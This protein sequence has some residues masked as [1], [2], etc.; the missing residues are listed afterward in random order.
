MEPG[1]VSQE[2]VH[3]EFGWHVIKVLD[4]RTAV[5]TFEE[6]EAERAT[7]P[8][9]RRSTSWSPRSTPAR[10]SSAST[11][12]ARR[13]PTRPRPAGERGRRRRGEE[14]PVSPLA[15]ERFPNPS[16][17]R[18]AV[19]LA[20]RGPALPGR[21]DVML[22]ELA[23]GSSVAGVLTRSTTAAPPGP[24][25]P[26]DPAARQGAGHHRQRR[27]RQRLHRQAGRQGGRGEAQAVG[28]GAGLPARGGVR[29]LDRRDRPAARPGEASR[30]VVPALIKGAASRRHRG[31]R[32][33]DHDHRHLPQGRHAPGQD[34]RRDRHHHRHPQGL[35]HDRAR[36]GDHAGLRLHRRQD[37]RAPC[38]RRC[39]PTRA[40]TSFNCDHR[41][42]RHLDQRHAAA[43]RHRR[44]R[45]R[46]DRG[47]RR[48]ACWPT[49]SARSTRC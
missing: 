9:T 5:P 6:K 4:R 11:S 39:S 46:A 13:R 14:P 16:G 23:P 49:S 24:L 26:R 17:A 41:R 3:S 2:P 7:R 8:R 29:G 28:A 48:P 12:T 44:G 1:T 32:R 36:H 19:G 22:L 30:A 21:D 45:P 37:R 34:R 35:G 33:R 40:D 25:V 18:R 38:C 31:R 15:P 47:G 43:A 42:R 10:R 20:A 27:Q